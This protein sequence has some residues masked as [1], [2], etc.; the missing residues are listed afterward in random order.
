MVSV[1]TP[2]WQIPGVNADKHL[3]PGT[4]H[5]SRPRAGAVSNS[6]IFMMQVM[7]SGERQNMDELSTGRATHSPKWRQQA[8]PPFLQK[9]CISASNMDEQ[10]IFLD[11]ISNPEKHLPA[12]FHA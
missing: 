10:T 9:L 2:L 8:V 6:I 5:D 3:A 7:C 4:G 11:D 1:P 12:S